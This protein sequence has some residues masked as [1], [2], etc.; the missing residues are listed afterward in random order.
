M[1]L[2]TSK[3]YKKNGGTN[4]TDVTIYCKRCK[5]SLRIKY[6]ITGDKNAMVLSNIQIAC[7]CCKRVMSPKNYTEKLLVENSVG[8]K[9]YM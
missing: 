5:K 3:I 2:T 7:H 1:S 4:M 8:G 6:N 9:F